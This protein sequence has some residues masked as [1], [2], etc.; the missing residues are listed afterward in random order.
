MRP[1][2]PKWEN[3]VGFANLDRSR[4]YHGKIKQILY[5]YTAEGWEGI[6]PGFGPLL[7]EKSNCCVLMVEISPY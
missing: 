3:F 1:H 6:L 5:I 2:S 4:P 7:N